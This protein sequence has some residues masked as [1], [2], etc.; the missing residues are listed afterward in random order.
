M[1]PSP[2]RRL[3]WLGLLALTAVV[4][5]GCESTEEAPPEQVEAS[6]ERFYTQDAVWDTCEDDENSECTR[7]EVPLDYADPEGDTIEIVAARSGEADP[8]QPVLLVNPGG[9]GSSGVDVVLD[10]LDTVT[11]ETLREAYTVVGFDPRGVSRSEPV[12]CLSDEE[13]DE[14]RQVSYDPA[15]EE[16]L[17]TAAEMAAEF[18][19]ACEENTS[20]VLRFVDTESAARD[21]DVLRSVLGSSEQLN[22]LGFSYGTKLGATYAELFPENVGTMVLDGALDPS[23]TEEEVATGQA[24]GFEQALA[25]WAAWCA[26]ESTCQAGTTEDDVVAAVQAA[27]EEAKENPQTAQ[28]GRT[29]PASTLVSGFITPLYSQQSWPILSEGFNMA[30]DGDPSMMLYFAD[31]N[32]G[33]EQDG[34]YSSNIQSAFTA[35]NCLDYPRADDPEQMRAHADQL[36]EASPTFG[37]YLAYGGINCAEWPHDGADSV[38]TVSAEG[39]APIL[40]I[41]TTGDPATPYEWSPA[42]AEQLDSG[43]LITNEG[44]GHGSYGPQN[45]CIATL[46]DDYFVDGT[47]PEDGTTC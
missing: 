25:S 21:M 16:G 9:P 44:E 33:R 6:L 11:T 26:E 12:R 32:A 14:Q 18:A 30:L 46:V 40:V 5:T 41:G 13:T 27:F 28:D 1:S 34:T 35:I 43:V 2:R 10:Y 38:D 37:A 20:E 8:D 31:L 39:A 22:Y 45:E 19:R 17:A 4:A 42:L 47:V 23:L 24:A 15:T 36:A 3:R 7:V 29:V